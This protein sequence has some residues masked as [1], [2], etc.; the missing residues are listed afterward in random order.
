MKIYYA[1][2]YSFIFNSCNV[3]Y[4]R[5]K[6]ELNDFFDEIEYYNN[7]KII[8]SGNIDLLPGESVCYYFN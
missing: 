7:S 1:K 5:N 3:S 6:A 8:D 4:F 2:V